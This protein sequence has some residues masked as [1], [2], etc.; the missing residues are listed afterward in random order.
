MN[1]TKRQRSIIFAHV[2]AACAITAAA[3]TAP[4]LG[5]YDLVRGDFT[6]GG[7]EITGATDY[8]L[9]GAIGRHDAHGP[10]TGLDYSLTG[11]V[12][13]P[14]DEPID[15]PG[16]SNGDLVVDLADLLDVIG[17]WGSDG[18]GGGDVNDDGAVNL[19][20]LLEVIGNWG[21]MCS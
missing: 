10:S 12:V 11:G 15:C 5:S 1:L 6:S 8:T 19:A 20:D 9:V 7:G 18:S 4:R 21:S 16:D 14:D 13:L 17:N 2:I 3:A